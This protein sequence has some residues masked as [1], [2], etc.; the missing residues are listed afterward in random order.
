MAQARA[1][2][3]EEQAR[4]HEEVRAWEEARIGRKP[5]GELSIDRNFPAAQPQSLY[6]ELLQEN[7]DEEEQERE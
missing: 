7:E 3:K 2:K 4:V 1:K 6:F 5:W